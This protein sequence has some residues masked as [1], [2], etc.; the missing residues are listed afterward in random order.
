MATLQDIIT[1]VPSLLDDASTSVF[2]ADFILPYVNTAQRKIS[3]YL[4]SKSIKQ[5][6]FRQ[7]SPMVVPAGTK[8][9]GYGRENTAQAPPNLV[10]FSKDFAI[11]AGKWSAGAYDTPTVT[12]AQAD[13]AGGVT[14]GKW[15]FAAGTA[16]EGLLTAAQTIAASTANTY[17]TISVWLKTSAAIPFTATVSA[18]LSGTNETSKAINVTTAW[19]QVIVTTGPYTTTGVQAGTLRILFP[20]LANLTVELAFPT[21]THTQQY[22]GYTA[23]AGLPVTAVYPPILPENFIEPDQMWEAKIGGTDQDFFLV[24]G[25][26]QIPNQAQT[27]TLGYWDFYDGEIRLLGATEDRLL[28]LDYWGAL[29][30]FQGSAVPAQAVVMQGFVNPIS[31]M[32]CKLIS[33]SRGQHSA[34]AEWGALFDVEMEDI[35]NI[36]QKAQQQA[37]VRRLS[38]RGASRYQGYFRGVG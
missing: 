11:A 20:V 14:A 32:V 24:V 25:P 1:T 4:A 31:Y 3:S 22:L 12:V 19:Q 35:A 5:A 17:V 37:P 29:E 23:T 21:I 6:K 7:D 34:A 26:H 2:T 13:P 30:N 9:I 16:H 36:Q 15:V 10:A 18:G 33:H 38:A 8:R 27:S 28:R